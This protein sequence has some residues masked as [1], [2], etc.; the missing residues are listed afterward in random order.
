MLIS[1]SIICNDD[2][3]CADA[4][5]NNDD[6]IICTISCIIADITSSKNCL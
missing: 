3:D 1:I 4:D 6:I 2:D 5:S